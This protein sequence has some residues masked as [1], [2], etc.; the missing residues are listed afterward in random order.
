MVVVTMVSPSSMVEAV[1]EMVEMTM[2]TPLGMV[3]KVV[4]VMEMGSSERSFLSSMIR[5]LLG[6]CCLSGTGKELAATV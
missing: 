5:Y 4:R 2:T 6:L 1:R 3:R